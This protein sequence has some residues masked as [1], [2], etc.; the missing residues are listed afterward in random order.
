MV[1]K[2]DSAE[3]TCLCFY[4]T[5]NVAEFLVFLWNSDSLA[6][7][8]QWQN[9]CL[10]MM[11]PGAIRAVHFQGADP[12]HCHWAATHSRW[13][14]IHYKSSGFLIYIY[15]YYILKWLKRI[16]F[17]CSP[18]PSWRSCRRQVVDLVHLAG[19]EGTGHW[20]NFFL[21]SL[22]IFQPLSICRLLKPWCE[23]LGAEMRFQAACSPCRFQGPPG[24]P[25][26]R[27]DGKAF[28]RVP[29]NL[30]KQWQQ[31]PGVQTSPAFRNVLNIFPTCF[32]IIS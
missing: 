19:K 24:P 5:W 29:Q 11:I 18:Q 31:V 20:H 8:G 30:K 6:P 26:E 15:I 25:T 1:G 9:R 3:T 22:N 16:T 2:H 12:D 14:R 17:T 21:T 4:M 13:G 28:Q 10:W 27:P 7:S 32:K 23:A